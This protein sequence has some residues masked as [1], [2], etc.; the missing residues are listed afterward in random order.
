MRVDEVMT[1]TVRSTTPETSLDKV[2]AMMCLNR[3]SGLPV[4]DA[5]RKLIG[6]VAERDILHFLFPTLDEMMD[7]TGLRDF[8]A[9]ESRYSSTLG[10]KVADVMHHGAVSVA[11]DTPLLRATS[12][13]VR[14]RFR[15]IPVTDGAG[16]LVGVVSIGDIHKALFQKHLL[17]KN[18][19]RI[20]A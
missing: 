2:A 13:M 8:E 4:V 18:P 3:L 17:Q 6:F 19:G 10:L 14:H 20:A 9:M 11:P 15:R 5:D 12:E 7:R 1:R 16:C